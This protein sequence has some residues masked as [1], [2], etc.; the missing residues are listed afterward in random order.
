M[1]ARRSRK[2]TAKPDLDQRTLRLGHLYP[3]QMNIYGD[4]GNILCLQRR[5]RLRGIQ[6]DVTPLE[7]GDILQPD[8]FDLLFMGGAQDREQHL[9]AGDLA[10][11][12]GALR[13]AV[14]DGVVFLGVCGG[15]QLSGRFYRG[16]EG[17]EM[18]GAGVF[19]LYTLHPGPGTKRLIGNLA[20]EWEGGS[21]AGFENHGGRTYLGSGA[22]PLAKV[23]RGHGNDGVS[24][25]EGARHKNAFGSYLHGPILPKNPVFADRLIS[26]ALERR[27]GD[28]T[29]APLDD[30]LEQLAHA[31]ALRAR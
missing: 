4:R 19:D 22:E 12:K 7:A 25:Y 1:T 9:V 15:Y 29:L 8:A 18:R 10:A 28:G 23:V 20:A 21:L 5:C 11:T 31:A 6:L 26:L 30:T 27:C 16:A 3:S 17:E 2:T 14:A 13:E 24:G